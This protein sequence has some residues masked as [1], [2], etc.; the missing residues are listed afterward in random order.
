MTQGESRE[1]RAKREFDEQLEG[2]LDGGRFYRR[3]FPAV[4]VAV[5]KTDQGEKVEIDDG[6][7]DT[8]RERP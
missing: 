7:G 4:K 5:V 3:G 6:R 1:E 2:A 8:Q